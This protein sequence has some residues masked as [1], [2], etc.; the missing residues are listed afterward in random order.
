VRNS[1][2]WVWKTRVVQTVTDSSLFSPYTSINYNETTT[3]YLV[4]PLQTS[5]RKIMDVRLWAW[6]E[7]DLRG[8]WVK[9]GV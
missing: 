5:T 7:G 8:E 4:I 3:Q 6:L 2:E 1:K 9:V